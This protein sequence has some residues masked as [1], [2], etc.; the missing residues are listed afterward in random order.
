MRIATAV[1]RDVEWR[2]V[3]GEW[4]VD[5]TRSLQS[6]TIML[7]VGWRMDAVWAGIFAVRMSRSR[8]INGL[9]AFWISCCVRCCDIVA[10]WEMSCTA[11]R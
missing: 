8:Q 7:V 6:V 1:R 3:C 5:R 4:Q 11:A 10:E 2:F 9:R